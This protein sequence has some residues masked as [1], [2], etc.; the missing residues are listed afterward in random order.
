MQIL[1]QRKA[2]S[3]SYTLFK[4]CIKSAPAGLVQSCG[5]WCD[6]NQEPSS[7]PV[8]VLTGNK[9]SQNSDLKY[10]DREADVTKWL[11]IS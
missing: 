1:A 4:G 11:S 9:K 5:D 3:G 6:T 8:Q 2:T 10:T 7:N